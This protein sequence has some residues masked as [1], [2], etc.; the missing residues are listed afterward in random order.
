[1]LLFHRQLQRYKIHYVICFYDLKTTSNKV[2]N[3]NDNVFIPSSCW[4]CFLFA[5]LFFALVCFLRCHFIIY[6]FIIAV[7]PLGCD[8]WLFTLKGFFPP[9]FHHTNG[10]NLKDNRENISNEESWVFQKLVFSFDV[11]VESSKVDFW[12]SY[13]HFW[14]WKSALSL[15]EGVLTFP[16]F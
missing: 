6:L 3:W 4:M 12:I 8:E 15:K 11:I 7:S 10:I 2:V 9:F 13:T 16:I 5:L 14:I 1:M